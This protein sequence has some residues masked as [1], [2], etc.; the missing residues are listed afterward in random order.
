MGGA[1]GRKADDVRLPSRIGRIPYARDYYFSSLRRDLFERLERVPYAHDFFQVLR[2]LECVFPDQPRIGT[3]PQPAGEP[4]RLTQRP[5][6]EFAPAAIAGLVRGAREGAPRIEQYFFGMLGPNGALPLHLTEFVRDRIVLENDPTLAR[7]LDILTHR[8]LALFY[9]AWAQAQPTVGLDR[10]ASDR[11]AVYVGSAVGI[12]TPKTAQRDVL[13]DHAKLYFAGL[14]ARQARNAEGLSAILSNYFGVPVRVEQYVGHWMALEPSE[15]SRIGRS[16]TSAQLGAN[17]VLGARVWDR[18]HKFRLWIGPL[19]RATY[20]RFLPRGD[21]LP[22]LVA[23]VRQYLHG[24]LEW[25]VRL[26]L[27]RAQAKPA[28]IGRREPFGR[29][30]WTTWLLPTNGVGGPRSQRAALGDLTLN[31]ERLMSR[32]ERAERKRSLNR[33]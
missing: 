31:A 13:P 10:P 12:G 15:R 21:W 26:Q 6:L 32:I 24:E 4:V 20:D 7:F 8:K 1:M 11:F 17:A 14:L 19:D 2:R 28:R 29:L 23:W 25:D 5:A 3:A 16:S 9:R 27:E 30:G 33:G 22:K 18:Q